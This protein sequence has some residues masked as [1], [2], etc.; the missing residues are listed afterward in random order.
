MGL[1]ALCVVS[2]EPLEH[3]T[4]G[5]LLFQATGDVKFHI[6]L[7]TVL[8]SKR[9]Y[10]IQHSVEFDSVAVVTTTE[11]RTIRKVL[12][13]VAAYPPKNESVI[14]PFRNQQNP[15]CVKFFA[16]DVF[17]YDYIAGS[18]FDVDKL[19]GFRWFVDDYHHP[20]LPMGMILCNYM[21]M[22]GLNYENRNLY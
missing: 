15:D 19:R 18:S 5:E 13:S 7:Q 12:K 22:V 11:S 14:L 8:A 2:S 6:G 4:S 20:E 3:H 1:T 17:Q 10:E 9:A 16:Y 21:G